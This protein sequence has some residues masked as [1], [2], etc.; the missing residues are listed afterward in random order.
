MTS[1]FYPH[2]RGL[3]LS[4]LA[5]LGLVACSGDGGQEQQMPP[6]GVSG[7]GRAAG[8]VHRGRGG[9][10]VACRPW[11]LSNCARAWAVLRT[12]ALPAKQSGCQGFAAV[13]R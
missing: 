8:R 2:A 7:G 3:R 13:Q 1:N 4:A 9:S 10:P 6:Q 11:T 5:A 12:D